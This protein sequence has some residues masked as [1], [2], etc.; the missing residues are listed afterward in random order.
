[1]NRR[2]F[3]KRALTAGVALFCAMFF[4]PVASE[5]SGTFRPFPPRPPAT[6]DIDQEKYELGRAI[7]TNRIRLTPQNL[8]ASEL[9]S[10]T[11]RMESL[12]R[13]LPR[14]IQN[15]IDLPAFAPLLTDEQFEALEYYLVRRYKLRAT[16]SAL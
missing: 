4:I 16:S 6:L 10:R 2:H 8:P 14:S 15:R 13:Q 9:R 12:Q 3:F 1:M 7:L 5:A 11:S